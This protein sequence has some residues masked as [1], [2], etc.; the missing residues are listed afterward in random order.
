MTKADDK[1]RRRTQAERSAETRKR[2]VAAAIDCLYRYGYS[3]TSTTLVAE[4]AVVSRGAMLHQFPTKVEMMAAVLDAVFDEQSAYYMRVLNRIDDPAER[5]AKLP[6]AAWNMFR[7]PAGVAQMEIF[8]AAR[9][10]SDL[11]SVVRDGNKRVD[12]ESRRG[13]KWLAEQVG[14]NDPKTIDALWGLSVS[15]VRG[16]QTQWINDLSTAP[17]EATLSLLEKTIR[18]VIAEQAKKK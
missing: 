18:N 14:I 11:K 8:L 16:L 1:P 5:L 2:I 10:D 4:L 15:T 12:A 7:R 17:A 9:S 13:V 3:S 6:H